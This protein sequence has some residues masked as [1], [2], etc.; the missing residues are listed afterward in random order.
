MGPQLVTWGP[1][2]LS[3]MIAAGSTHKGGRRCY[4]GSFA[5]DFYEPKAVSHV[6][7]GTAISF[8]FS[9]CFDVGCPTK[10]G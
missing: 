7:M 4:T 9:L 6:Q 3:R 1:Q 10:D 8:P 5:A 2:R